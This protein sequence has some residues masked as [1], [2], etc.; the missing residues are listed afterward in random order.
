MMRHLFFCGALVLMTSVLGCST[1]PSTSLHTVAVSASDQACSSDSDCVPVFEGTVGCCGGC[2]NAA[3]N[4][5]AYPGYQAAIA[6][7]VP[8]C[9]PA[10]PCA[11]LSDAICKAGAI[12]RGGMCAF[13]SLTADASAGAN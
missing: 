3:I 12:C 10:P 4:K 11:F 13:S 2:A 8:I 5:A 1:S 7:S 9:D 6:A